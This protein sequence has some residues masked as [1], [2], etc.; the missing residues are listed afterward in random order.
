MPS[1]ASSTSS[2][3]RGGDGRRRSV[4]SCR[5]LRGHVPLCL[6]DPTRSAAEAAAF[7]P[8]FRH[9]ALLAQV[10]GVDVAAAASRRRR[11]KPLDERER[12]SSTSVR[13]GARAWLDGVAPWSAR[14]V[15]LLDA[16]PRLCRSADRGA[17]PVPRASPRPPRPEPTPATPGRTA[18]LPRRSHA[19]LVARRLRRGLLGVPRTDQRPAGG[20]AAGE[21]RST[22]VR[23]R[24]LREAAG[25]TVTDHRAVSVGL[26]RLREDAGR[27]PEG[28]ID[29][30][31]DPAL[32]DA[33]ARGSTRAPPPARRRRGAQGR[34]QAASKRIG[35]AIKWRAQP[36]GPEVADLR[37]RRWRGE[38]I[39]GRRRSPRS[40][41]A[42]GPAAAHPQPAR[43]GRPGRWRGGQRHRPRLGRAGCPGARRGDGDRAR[44]TGS[45]RGARHHR[46]PRGAKI[47]GSGFPVYKGAARAPAGADR[48]VPRRPHP[49][50]RHDRGLAAGRR[51]RGLGA[52]TGQIPDKEDQM[53]VVTR[54]ELY[55]VPTAEVPVTNLHRDEILEATDLPI[56]YVAYSPCFRRE[57]GAAGKDTRGILARPPVRQGRDGPVRATGGFGRGARVDDRAGGDAPPAPGPGLPGRS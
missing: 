32:V 8:P 50:E 24:R 26:Q 31:E 33:G 6:L 40:R 27:H 42:R 46:H 53:Y 12:R 13:R 23:R 35:E 28:A 10:P 34:A 25:D 21:P 16:L 37:E 19:G 43:P 14:L 48:L 4:A 55:L 20:L 38:R 9:L 2:T 30:G 11:G 57:A 54:D 3:V 47:A 45:R 41:P 49:R 51:Q 56:R 39:A 18:H 17:A 44:R 1:R 29:K 7:R 52:G 22:G 5:R 36:D 15:V